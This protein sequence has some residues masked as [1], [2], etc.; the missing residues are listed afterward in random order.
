[1][2]FVNMKK[3]NQQYPFEL[4]KVSIFEVCNI[5]KTSECIK[6]SVLS[7]RPKL[8]PTTCPL[9]QNPG[10]TFC[11]RQSRRANLLSDWPKSVDL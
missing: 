10:D 11:N 3:N 2:G 7:G 8:S 1:M 5:V 6:P 4:I 9:W